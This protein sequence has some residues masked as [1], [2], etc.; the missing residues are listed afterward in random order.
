MIT[1]GTNEVQFPVYV[2]AEGEKRLLNISDHTVD[3]AYNAAEDL[4][5]FAALYDENGKLRSVSQ[6]EAKEGPNTLHFTFR[7]EVS[8]ETKE[9]IALFELN[10]NYYQP[11]T[12]KQ[13]LSD[14]PTV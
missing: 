5:V 14:Y 10:P 8:N 1:Y 13:M 2:L 12:A 6:S 11:Q 4:I 9:R 3:I 7:T